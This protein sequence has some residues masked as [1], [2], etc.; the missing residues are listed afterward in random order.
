MKLGQTWSNLVVVHAGLRVSSVNT[1]VSAQKCDLPWCVRRPPQLGNTC[2]LLVGG[3]APSGG[4]GV[5][6]PGLAVVP[7]GGLG[8]LGGLGVAAL[9]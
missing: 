6:A 9:V 8:G 2:G 4:L 3:T 1:R 7:G 5:G